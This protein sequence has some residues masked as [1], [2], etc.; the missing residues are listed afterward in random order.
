MKLVPARHFDVPALTQLFNA[1]FSGYRFPMHLTEEAFRDH[2][3]L[4]DIDLDSSQVVVDDGPVAFALVGRREDTG[5]IGGIGT[6]PSR[7]RSG[8]GEK[9]LVGAIEAAA[10]RGCSEIFLEVLDTNEPAIQ[11]YEKLGF[12]LVR[13]LAVWSLA[14]AQSWIAAHRQT[15]EPW[16]RADGTIAA[17]QSRGI[18]LRGLVVE[19]GGE[20]VAAAIIREQPEAAAVVQIAACDEDAAAGLLSGTTE[21]GRALR[22]ANVPI[23]DPGARAIERLGADRVAVQHEMALST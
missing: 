4:Y 19:R 16:Q 13:D 10:H 11:L 6:T 2:L 15:P 3:A 7:R 22:L 17:L 12:G 23:D 21:A 18:E 20:P 9:A 8:L 1:G 14:R 5:W